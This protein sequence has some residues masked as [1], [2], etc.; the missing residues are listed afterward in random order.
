MIKGGSKHFR[1]FKILAVNNKKVTNDGRYKTK[2][3]PQS[4]A[5]KAFTQLSKQ[6]KTNKLTICIKET[7]QGSLKKEY[8]PYLVQKIKLKKPLEVVF[9]GTP[10]PIKYK[11]KIRSLKKQMQKGG[12]YAKTQIRGGAPRRPLPSGRIPALHAGPQRRRP[13]P[14][15]NK[16]LRAAL[17]PLE[18]QLGLEPEDVLLGALDQ[19]EHLYTQN[20][21]PKIGHTVKFDFSALRGEKRLL[22]PQQDATGSTKMF[23]KVPLI[24]KGTIID[25][26]PRR[27]KVFTCQNTMRQGERLLVPCGNV[28]TSSID[29]PPSRDGYTFPI[30]RNNIDKTKGYCKECDD[31]EANG[32]L[33]VTDTNIATLRIVRGDQYYDR[34][35]SVNGGEGPYEDQYQLQMK[36]YL[37]K[38]LEKKGYSGKSIIDVDVDYDMWESGA[39]LCKGRGS[40]SSIEWDSVMR[41]LKL[42]HPND[43]IFPRSSVLNQDGTSGEPERIAYEQD[44]Q[45]VNTR[46]PRSKEPRTP[47]GKAFTGMANAASR[48]LQY[49]NWGTYGY[50]S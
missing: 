23:H 26:R 15:S 34:M 48:A 38:F 3:S 1:Y 10:V 35:I 2:T 24:G 25:I 45:I 11:T 44:L 21:K 20:T 32:R 43:F 40:D 9:N 31:D 33:V 50:I 47:V 46:A 19:R 41:K 29:C 42:I 37:F 12:L 18:K 39:A 5:K 17:S 28:T 30:N 13:L 16:Q 14:L 36:Y 22:N 27:T 4:A 49:C 6:Y 7:T 8:G